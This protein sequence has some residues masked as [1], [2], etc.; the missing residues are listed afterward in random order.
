MTVKTNLVN[1]LK[2]DQEAEAIAAERENLEAANRPVV[3]GKVWVRLVRPHF[4]ANN[5]LHQPGIVQLD[6][7]AVP[8]TA[9]VLT[10]AELVE[11]GKAEEKEYE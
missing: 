1:Q 2:R 11:A 6:A 9:K 5:V 8:K 10:P 7:D 4:D 3:S